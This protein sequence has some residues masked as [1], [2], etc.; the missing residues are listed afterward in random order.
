MNPACFPTPYPG[1]SLYSILCR[2]HV[3][4]C[5]KNDIYTIAQ[6]FGFRTSI[7]YTVLSP[8]LLAYETGWL[9]ELSGIT[10]ESLMNENTAFR[11]SLPFA[12]S[13]G[14]GKLS[15]ENNTSE[16]SCI[17]RRIHRKISIRQ[18]ASGI[19]Q[20]VQQSRNGCSVKLIGEFSHRWR[21]TKSAISM[22]NPY[23][24]ALSHLMRYSIN[25]IRL[26]AFFPAAALK[27][28]GAWTR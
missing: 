1:E 9:K 28:T 12:A 18:N 23:E 5:N 27:S 4:S 8:A 16:K 21:D 26:P 24:K 25:F 10:M 14:P 7:R 15:T 11:F 3:R 17:F 13:F 2:Y 22:V 19:V 6:L 20:N